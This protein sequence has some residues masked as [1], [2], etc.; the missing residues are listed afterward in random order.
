MLLC[1]SN[2]FGGTHESL[3]CGLLGGVLVELFRKMKS[4]YYWYDFTVRGERYR[5]STKETNET[6]RRRLPLLNS[7]PLLRAATR[8]IGSRPRFVNTRRISFNGWKRDGSR[9]TAAAITE[10][11]GDYWSRQRS[12]ECARTRS[13]K[14]RSKSCSFPDPP[15]T[16][17][18]LRTLRRMYSKAKEHKARMLDQLRTCKGAFTECICHCYRF[19]VDGGQLVFIEE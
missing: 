11:A 5:G 8:S 4:K 15:R 3:P 16:G 1:R 9:P 12:Q 18:A 7:P 10:T 14:T 17:N 13:P 6:R 2:P 19:R